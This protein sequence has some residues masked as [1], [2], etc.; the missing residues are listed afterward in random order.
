MN[1]TITTGSRKS[2]TLMIVSSSNC[3][4]EPAIGFL[5]LSKKPTY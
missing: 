4:L 3:R 5:R 2:S 1:T